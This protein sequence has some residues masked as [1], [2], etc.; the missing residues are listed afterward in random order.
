MILLTLS[1]H[2]IFNGN[3]E[4]FFLPLR[5]PV[6]TIDTL[7][8]SFEV[9]Q[10][11]ITTTDLKK[12]KNNEDYNDLYV[13]NLHTHKLLHSNIHVLIKSYELIFL[14]KVSTIED[15]AVKKKLRDIEAKIQ[16]HIQ[17]LQRPIQYANTVELTR[18]ELEI[19]NA[20]YREASSL[21]EQEGSMK[22]LVKQKQNGKMKLY[23]KSNIY[24]GFPYLS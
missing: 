2:K 8:K 3:T 15:V 19:N 22:H 11:K 24:I 9:L 21:T 10:G 1:F 20:L 17:Y 23:I 18:M 13:R 14:L 6:D 12:M 7:I 5:N 4:E 16:K